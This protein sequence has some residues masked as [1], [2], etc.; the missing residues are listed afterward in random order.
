[1]IPIGENDL[2][3]LIIAKFN[4]NTIMDLCGTLYKDIDD[5]RIQF[6]K[7]LA[8]DLFQNE[9]WRLCFTINLLQ[10]HGVENISDGYDFGIDMDLRAAQL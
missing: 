7:C 1:M 10:C 6:A 9:I 8:F 4:P 3:N 5:R 2:T